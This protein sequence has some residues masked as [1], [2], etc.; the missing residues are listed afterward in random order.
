M[1]RRRKPWRVDGRNSE[2]EW[3]RSYLADPKETG[4]TSRDGIGTAMV[5]FFVGLNTPEHAVQVVKFVVH[6]IV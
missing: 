5:V 6:S 3:I 2:L 1:T 4:I